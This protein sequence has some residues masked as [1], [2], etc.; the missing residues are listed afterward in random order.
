MPEPD[1]AS[2]PDRSAAA[3]GVGGGAIPKPFLEFGLC[4]LDRSVPADV[5]RELAAAPAEQPFWSL[6]AAFQLAYQGFPWKPTPA[7]EEGAPLEGRRYGGLTYPSWSEIDDMLKELQ[8]TPRSFHLNE[9]AKCPY[10]SG[11]LQGDT[12][13]LRLVDCLVWKY[14]ALHIQINLTAGGVPKHLFMPES[15][16]GP[17]EA[18]ARSVSQVQ[19]LCKEHPGT[20]FIVPHAKIPQKDGTQIDT[21]AFVALLLAGDIVPPNLCVFFDNSAGTGLEPDAVPEVPD[22]YPNGV[23]QPIGFTG[24]IHAGNVT[25]WLDKYAARAQQHG[26]RLVCDAQSGF[27]KGR[28]RNEPVDV[29]ELRALVAAVG[30]WGA[31]A[32]AAAGGADSMGL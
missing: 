11:L 19:Q 2:W 20:L 5:L 6:V 17:S 24:G 22:G 18:V 3:A 9:T 10:V 30:A 26:C 31:A 27:R 32:A 29:A 16:T 28:Q 21:S 23:S 8:A 12:Q 7:Y 14:G 4:G 15:G 13:T 1:M 25:Q